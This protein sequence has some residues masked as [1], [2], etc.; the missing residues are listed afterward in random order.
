[1][2]RPYFWFLSHTQ[3]C[4][5]IHSLVHWL[6]AS[7]NEAF[8]TT[9]FG[10]VHHIVATIKILN[11]IASDEKQPFGFQTVIPWLFFFFRRFSE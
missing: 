7:L 11:D 2:H 9:F 4:A 6:A 1:M 5:Q 3:L 10:R 8:Q